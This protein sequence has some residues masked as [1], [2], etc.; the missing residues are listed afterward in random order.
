MNTTRKCSTFNLYSWIRYVKSKYP[1]RV[2]VE[3]KNDI[4][5]K[6]STQTPLGIII[7]TFPTSLPVLILTIFVVNL[8]QVKS[9]IDPE[10]IPYLLILYGTS[11]TPERESL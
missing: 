6:T 1:Y 8:A 10:T 11:N 5:P 4:E 9:S 7:F 3:F 2:G